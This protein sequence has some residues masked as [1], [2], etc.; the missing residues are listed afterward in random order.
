M[1]AAGNPEL[2]LRKKVSRIN[3]LPIQS[4]QAIAP[5][6]TTNLVSQETE[7]VT[8]SGKLSCQRSDLHESL[9]LV[10]KVIPE[11]NSGKPILTYVRLQIDAT[12]IR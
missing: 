7:A 2:V 3:P 4:M 11:E 8:T 1:F 5:A 6:Q 9:A 10:A 12:P